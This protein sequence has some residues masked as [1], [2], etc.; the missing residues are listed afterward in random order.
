M[1][2]IYLAKSSSTRQTFHDVM[3]F[4][5]YW[6]TVFPHRRLIDH[7]VESD[8]AYSAV[9]R[10]IRASPAE[11]VEKVSARLEEVQHAIQFGGKLHLD[12]E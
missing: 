10:P 2:W 12:L 5:F 3:H 6:M 8:S 7:A 1:Y 4:I 11:A 9:D